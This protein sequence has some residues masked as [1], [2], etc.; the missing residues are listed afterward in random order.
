M[1]VYVYKAVTSH[2]KVV[3]GRTEEVSRQRMVEK[4]RSNNLTPI[5]INEQ[6]N[7]NIM[8]YIMPKQQK[9]K[10][11]KV[12]AVAVTKL[13]KEKLIA[14]QQKRLQKG[15]SR[16]IDIDLSAFA[17]IKKDDIIAFTQS[18]FLLKRANFT[19]TRALA[20]LLENTD[21]PR[22]KDVIEDILNGVEAGDYIY[23]TLEYYTDIFPP[24]YVSIIKVGEMSGDLVTALEQ[25]LIYIT[26]S[27]ATSR[28]VKKAI[29]GP[30]I[31]TLGMLL[32]TIIGVIVGVPVLEGL[33]AD[34]G[35]KDQIPAATVAFSNFVKACGER[36][37]LIVALI[38]A[39]FVGFAMWKSTVNGR[40]NW[41]KFKLKMPIF[42][43]LITRLALQKFFKAMQLNLA[44]NAKLQ[45]ALE[46]SK[47]VVSNYVMLSVIEAAQDNLQQGES[48]VEPFATLPNMPTMALEML[49]IGMETDIN[50]MISKIVEFINDDI[51]LTI[52]RIVKILPEVST[53][54]MGIVMIIFII[55]ILRPVVELYT[56][57]Y[58][59]EAYG[60]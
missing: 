14:E 45:D 56:G 38:A 27:T 7:S 59:F 23:S 22:M 33:Y 20:T 16:E 12:S 6:K 9:A 36:W 35:V 44:N 24:I 3:S 37:Y 29:S 58:L 4:L 50:D 17:R 41:D 5:S 52:S 13:A 25:A 60:L 48:W 34:M 15:L 39:I 54:I 11:N 19:N 51:Q 10:R 28:A 31:Q 26:E 21:N 40:Y 46:I 32:L 57:A 18:M 8:K 30:L 42:G 49:R 2:G 55:V 43:P 47:D 53:V 1:P